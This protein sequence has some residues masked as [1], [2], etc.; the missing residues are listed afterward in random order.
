MEQWGRDQRALARALGLSIEEWLGALDGASKRTSGLTAAVIGASMARG[1]GMSILDGFDAAT[2]L[3]LARQL[4][5]PEPPRVENPLLKEAIRRADELGPSTGAARLKRRRREEIRA[6][7]R[8]SGF[9][10]SSAETSTPDAP[11]SKV[12]EDE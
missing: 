10:A 6:P 9:A 11:G 3:V 4:V 12:E 1:L 8:G 7:V 5:D 2:L